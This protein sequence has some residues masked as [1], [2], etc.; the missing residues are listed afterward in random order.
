[1]LSFDFSVNLE[2]S[3][4][5]KQM[6]RVKSCTITGSESKV[7]KP[8]MQSESMVTAMAKLFNLSLLQSFN[9]IK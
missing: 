7:E 9:A 1:M 2:L 5:K 6:D 8:R 4:V 3:M